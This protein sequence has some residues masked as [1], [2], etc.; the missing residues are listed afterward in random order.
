MTKLPDDTFLRLYP[1]VKQLR[2]IPEDACKTLTW[3]L[4]NTHNSQFPFFP[5]HDCKCSQVLSLWMPA[6]F[7]CGHS[8]PLGE[9]LALPQVQ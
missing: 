4:V 3:H 2:T 8:G 1:I 9:E 5:F 6:K 7:P